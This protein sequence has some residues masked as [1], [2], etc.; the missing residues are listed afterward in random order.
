MILNGSVA[1]LR[2]DN[3]ESDLSIDEDFDDEGYDEDTKFDAV[4][5][6]GDSFGVSSTLRNFSIVAY[7]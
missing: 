5:R 2:D 1:V 6:N 4:L 3:D 7:S